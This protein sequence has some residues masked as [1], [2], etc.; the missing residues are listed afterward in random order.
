MAALRYQDLLSGMDMIRP[1]SNQIAFESVMR[2]A[3]SSLRMKDRERAHELAK[4]QAELDNLASSVAG[5]KRL[6]S[7]LGGSFGNLAGSA[8]AGLRTWDA[9]DRPTFSESDEMLRDLLDDYFGFQ[10]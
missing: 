5:T 3:I 6:G 8:L 9:N 7:A 10:G 1:Y 4:R 2:P